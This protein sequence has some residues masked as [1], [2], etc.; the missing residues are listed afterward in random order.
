MKIPEPLRGLSLLVAAGF[1]LACIAGFILLRATPKPA[2]PTSR[3]L[4]LTVWHYYSGL[5]QRA[6][7]DLAARFNTTEGARLG[8]V[9]EPHSQGDIAS[10]ADMVFRAARG[11]LGAPN[12][13]DIFAAY[14][15]SAFRVAELTALANLEPYL[16][17]A[18]QAAYRPEFLEDGRMGPD[19]GLVIFPVAKSTENLFLNRTDWDAF[20]A[21]TGATLDALATW[22]GVV[23]TAGRYHE[24]SGGR[25]FFR[26]DSPA[27]FILVAAW[28]LGE[29]PYALRNGR[30]EPTL[31]PR[32]ARALWDTYH[33]PFVRGW[34]AQI[35]PFC[36]YDARTGAIVAYIGSS[37][38][39]GYFPVEVSECGAA[40]PID[41][42]VLPYPRFKEGEPYAMLQGAGLCVV[43]S[44]PERERAAARFLLW[45]TAPDQ[46][47]PFAALTGYLP[48]AKAA[49]N[50]ERI[51]GALPDSAVTSTQPAV[52]CS[53]RTSLAM[54]ND[55]RLTGTRPF[56]GSYALRE[57][58]NTLLP[59][60]A[61]EALEER[62]QRTAAGESE[63]TAVADLLSE[64]AFEQWYERL[65][66][67]SAAA[68]GQ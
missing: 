68:L 27:N 55:M 51:L 8:I 2:T 26:L 60:L 7:H 4:T 49:L 46:N 35:L 36:S 43:K 22:E 9:I 63:E 12:M 16:T 15:D 37:A 53:L 61:Q 42:D 10:L 44:T 25:A 18:E 59:K 39:A 62:K 31:T 29:M 28:Q 33:A 13:P 47:L 3:P 14:P 40:R 41:C 38:W 20:A 34:Y 58:W 66:R 64:R 17:P 11:D 54:L 65:R 24:W 48:P 5:T 56:A 6:F 67:E 21:A 30:A 32:L 19:N 23:R 52:A 1:A 57:R 50:E 45:L